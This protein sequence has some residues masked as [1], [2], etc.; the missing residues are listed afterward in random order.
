[1]LQTL[2]NKIVDPYIKT[3]PKSR[4]KLIMEKKRKGCARGG[5]LT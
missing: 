3:P 4:K 1:M 2:N 5:Y